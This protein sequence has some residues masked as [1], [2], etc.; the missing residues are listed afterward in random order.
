MSEGEGGAL[1]A[2][3]RMKQGTMVVVGEMLMASFPIQHE[4][5]WTIGLQHS[6]GPNARAYCRCGWVAPPGEDEAQVSQF[7]NH[8]LELQDD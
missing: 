4:G 7:I 3:R 5:L 2:V 1:S 6:G 8:L